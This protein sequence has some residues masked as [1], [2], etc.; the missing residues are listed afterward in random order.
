MEK[1]CLNDGVDAAI[2]TVKGFAKGSDK[3]NL[4][5][6][7]NDFTLNI[8]CGGNNCDEVT[9][10]SLLTKDES[11]YYPL[12]VEDREYCY[13]LHEPTIRKFPLDCFPTFIRQIEKTAD[14][15]DDE[16]GTLWEAWN[17]ISWF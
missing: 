2:T 3:V 8:I 7:L 4:V 17:T 5:Y 13:T 11:E 14:E 10:I 12:I 1:I 6:N 15:N 9:E 16:L